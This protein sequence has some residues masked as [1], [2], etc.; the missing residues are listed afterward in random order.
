LRLSALVLAA[1]FLACPGARAQVRQPVWTDDM[2]DQWVFQQDRNAA[3]ARQRLDS[4]LGLRIEEVDRASQLT[5]AQ[6]KKLQLAG[7]GDMRRFFARYETVKKKFQL[8]KNDQNKI[9]QIWQ[10]I[11]PLQMS[12]QAGL[13]HED[14]LLVKS[15][16]HTL[17][18]E[19]FER[20]DA[21]ARERRAFRHRATIEL[22]VALLEQNMPLRASQ[23]S[24]LIALL[25]KQTKPARKSGQYEYYV[26]MVQLGRVPEVKLKPLFDTMQWQVVKHQLDQLK[27][28]E[29]FLRQSGEWPDG[30]DEADK[31][32]ARPPAPLKK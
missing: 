29:P 15:L 25:T 2:F 20:Y 28:M 24:D 3:G 21:V 22:T 16:P 6:K 18:A 14:S 19:Q 26:I 12:L 4:L 9:N 13:F 17:T 30:D 10:D 5:D 23:R 7:K 32:D 1:A 27:R 31:A 8:V 11:S